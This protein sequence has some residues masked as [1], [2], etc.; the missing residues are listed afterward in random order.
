[1]KRITSFFLLS[2]W[3]LGSGLMLLGWPVIGPAQN[4]DDTT[5]GKR[6][7]AL[8]RWNSMPS[9][10]RIAL[11]RVHSIL[12]K[13]PAMQRKQLIQ[14][15]RELSPDDAPEV[16]KRLRKYMKSSDSDRKDVRQR[17]T[18]LRLWDLQLTKEDRQRFRQCST[19]EKKA[20]LDE[21]INLR[22]PKLL[23]SLSPIE[24][25]K[26]ENLPPHEQ[27]LMLMGRRIH[28]SLSLSKHG[29]R[30]MY[31][32]RHL[33]LAQMNHFIETGEVDES[34]PNLQEAVAQLSDEMKQ[35]IQNLLG[36]GRDRRFRPNGTFRPPSSGGQDR[37]PAPGSRGRKNQP[38][39]S[40]EEAR[41]P[42]GVGPRRFRPGG[43]DRRPPQELRRRNSHEGSAPRAHKALKKLE[44][45]PPYRKA[46]ALEGLHRSLED[47]GAFD[48]NS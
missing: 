13:I 8:E 19:A 46:Q 21:Q 15:L 5:T 41:P 47:L 9:E 7:E 33:T 2:C 30:V 14:R 44:L 42:S 38:G 16:V 3:L 36:K 37:R 28:R 23:A 20:F 35:R 22:M 24:R 18:A 43:S 11:A 48:H 6:S 29:H 45:A 25:Q 12:Q 10:R 17:R 27:R 26:I 4:S 32:A 31:L 39:A 40:D 34:H 1:M